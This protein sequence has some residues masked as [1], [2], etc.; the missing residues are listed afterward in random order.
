MKTSKY[1]MPFPLLTLSVEFADSVKN[2]KRLIENFFL[3]YT[4]IVIK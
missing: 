1:S 2:A 3:F 4:M